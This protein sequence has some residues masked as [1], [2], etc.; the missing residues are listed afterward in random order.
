MLDL[1]IVAMDLEFTSNGSFELEGSRITVVSRRMWNILH[2]QCTIFSRIKSRYSIAVKLKWSWSSQQDKFLNL[3]LCLLFNPMIPHELL[4]NC[5]EW[6]PPAAR[7]GS[8]ISWGSST[9]D[10]L[11]FLYSLIDPQNSPFRAIRIEP[12]IILSSSAII[13]YNVQIEY[14]RTLWRQPST[15][16]TR[17]QQTRKHT[18]WP[19]S[20]CGFSI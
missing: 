11:S 16:Y 18:K 8:G 1:F 12:E 6:V 9:T 19:K 4:T 15:T 17:N 3:L 20:S 13:L 5:L 2:S 14:N 7:G 10:I